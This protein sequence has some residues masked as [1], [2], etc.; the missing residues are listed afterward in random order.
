M[1][2]HTLEF[3]WG[4]SRGRDT[5]GYNI[6]S[7]YVDG[8][9]AASCN[10]GGYDMKGTCLGNFIASA[11]TDRLVQLKPEQMEEHSHFQPDNYRECRGDCLTKKRD[12]F[13]RLLAVEEYDRA[14]AV[15]AT[16]LPHLPEDC[17]ECPKCKG[18][19]APTRN[20]KRINDGRYF[21][22]LTFH[23]PNFDPGKAII[24]KD[25]T[26][27]TL[28]KDDTGS[29]GKTVEQAEKDGNSFGLERYQAFYS[30]S[31]KVPTERHAVPRIDGACGFSSV[32]RIAKAIGIT[33]EYVPTRGKNTVY[34]LHDERN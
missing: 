30:A 1:N 29:A 25:C 20:G 23:D 16:K 5:Y 24:G 33:L 14:D 12:E 28:T 7:L 32:E 11:Y 6:C 22:G 18:A 15:E 27:R 17:Y 8:R 9:K 31:S 13:H 2:K 3:K 26:D 21:Y 19:T 34:Q 4:V 10:G